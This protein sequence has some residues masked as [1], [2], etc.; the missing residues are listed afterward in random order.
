MTLSYCGADHGHTPLRGS[1][2]RD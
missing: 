1:V 2:L